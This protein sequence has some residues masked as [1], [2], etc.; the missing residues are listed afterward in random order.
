V[1]ATRARLPL[2]AA[3]LGALAAREARAQSTFDVRYLLYKESGGR[4]EVANPWVFLNQNFGLKGGQLSLLLGYDTISGASPTG[5]YP[6][7]DGTTSASGVANSSIPLAQYEDTRKSVTASYAHKFGA[8]LPS[9][10]LSYSKENDYLAR[11]AGVTDAWTLAKGRGTLHL[12]VSLSRDIVTPV[13]THV[14]HPKSSNAYALG[15]SWILGAKDLL[16]LSGSYTALS[17]YLDDPYKIVPVGATTVPEHRPDARSRYAALLKYGHFFVDANAALKLSY[18]YYWDDWSIRAHTLDLLYDQ[19]LGSRWTLSPSARVYTQSHASFFGYSFA[20]PQTYMSADYRLSALH[21][22]Q[23]GLT[24]AYAIR[25]DLVISLG[26]TYQYQR[27]ID[28]VLPIA[29]V[30][31]LPASALE[32]GDDGDGTGTIETVSAADLSIL[33]GTIGLTWRY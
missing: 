14:D 4:T 23:G 11:G 7:L 30:P 19:R 24:I 17:G 15:W 12:G 10:D 28:R 18:R 16:D 31:P 25:P 8:H 27:G 21:S 1:A 13:T 20:T 32:D 22:A 5:G 26:A 9:I 33:T 6:T 3:G 29:A 2:I